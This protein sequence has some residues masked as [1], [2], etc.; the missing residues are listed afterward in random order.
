M[1]GDT[2]WQVIIGAVIVAI[3]FTLVRPNSPG[4]SAIS[5]ISTALE[6]IIHTTTS[7]SVSNPG[8]TG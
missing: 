6:D 3:I 1:N 4:A 7:Y 5:Q 8:V 2:I